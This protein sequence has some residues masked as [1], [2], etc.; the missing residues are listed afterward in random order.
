MPKVPTKSS[1]DGLKKLQLGGYKAIFEE[2]QRTTDRLL[3]MLYPPPEYPNTR[4][5]ITKKRPLAN[6]KPK[7]TRK[8]DAPQEMSVV[9]S[10]PSASAQKICKGIMV[11]L[12]AEDP[13]T[14]SQERSVEEAIVQIVRARK[15]NCPPEFFGIKNHKGILMANVVDQQSEDWLMKHQEHI[16]RECG[17]KLKV[18]KEQDIPSPPVFK[19]TFHESSE[20]STADILDTLE[21]YSRHPLP[22]A[23]WFLQK[24]INE[25]SRATLILEV[26]KK[27][28]S[29]F[30][31]KNFQ[32][33]Y[34]MGHATAEK[35]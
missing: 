21:S 33:P 18:Y 24:R 25:G 30:E 2:R 29:Y 5:K 8:I 22:T 11:G 26:D 1:V 32:L 6:Q 14:E 35:L 10:K 34:R 9:E 17:V 23:Q 4:K 15:S 31:S 13:I 20:K 19:M 12:V 27:S 16:S 28:A 7:S 3:D